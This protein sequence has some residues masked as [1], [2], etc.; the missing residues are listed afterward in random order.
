MPHALATTALILLAT[1]PV[2]G[3][4]NREAKFQAMEAQRK[5]HAQFREK[6]RQARKAPGPPLMPEG[7]YRIPFETARFGLL[8]ANRMAR[9]LQPA[10]TLVL[11]ATEPPFLGQGGPG[12]ALAP[13]GLLPLAGGAGTLPLVA[14]R[15]E[16]P[17]LRATDGFEPLLPPCE[18][19]APAQLG[20]RP[21]D[22]MGRGELRVP[23]GPMPDRTVTLAFR[24]QEPAGP[25]KGFLQ[26][27]DP[28]MGFTFSGTA[29]AVEVLEARPDGT[30]R[31]V[32]VQG[33]SA[34]HDPVKFCCTV[35]AAPE[36]D[37]EALPRISFTLQGGPQAF[38]W[39]FLELTQGYLTLNGEPLTPNKGG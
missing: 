29:R 18:A 14:A 38:A 17:M 7:W 26:L 2:H 8:T 19:P 4:P 12:A 32:Q 22:L 11:L 25:A 33:E 37:P 5:V 3:D 16:A 35:A 23:G 6:A 9:L 1:L 24:V 39:P 20:N 34:L 28:A 30:P 13:A 31:V 21:V 27:K 15:E 10:L 36:G